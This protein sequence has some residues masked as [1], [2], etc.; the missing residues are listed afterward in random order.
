MITLVISALAVLLAHPVWARSVPPTI[1]ENPDIFNYL[2]LS[3]PSMAPV[4]ALYDAGSKEEALNTWRDIVVNRFRL[5]DFGSGLFDDYRL[6]HPVP[7]NN[8]RILI[9]NLTASNYEDYCNISAFFQ[10]R[11]PSINWFRQKPRGKTDYFDETHSSFTSLYYT[12]QDKNVIKAFLDIHSSYFYDF[13]QQ[14]WNIYYNSTLNPAARPGG[15]EIDGFQWAE[16]TN[17]LLLAFKTTRTIRDFAGLIK[18]IGP[19]RPSSV[20]KIMQPST[21]QLQR[22]D[23]ALIDAKQLARF[24]IG[25]HEYAFGPCYQFASSIGSVGNQRTF[26][27]GTAHLISASFEEYVN[28]NTRLKLVQDGLQ[29]FLKSSIAPDGTMVEHSFNYNEHLVEGISD[30]LAYLNSF[31]TGYAS[32]KYF[33]YETIHAAEKAFKKLT[34]PTGGLPYMAS[35]MP[36]MQQLALSGPT[37]NFTSV[38]LPYAGY[39]VQRNGWAMNSSFPFFLSSKK[40]PW[41][42]NERCFEHPSPSLW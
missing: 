21:T 20:L 24:V 7:S 27:F 8:V 19:D 34:L 39:F 14:W 15:P 42:P 41:S 31:T 17:Q 12:T 4:K 26:A 13:P 25:L 22:N 16:H 33:L 32:L 11:A 38:A 1:N 6:G 5:R 10:G 37:P 18:S 36:P 2:N 3:V 40:P 30:L 29:E 23:T 35:A 28:Q 9:G